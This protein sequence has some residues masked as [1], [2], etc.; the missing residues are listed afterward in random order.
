M[1]LPVGLLQ[2]G[3]RGCRV[4]DTRVSKGIDSAETKIR[5]GLKIVRYGLRTSQGPDRIDYSLVEE[6]TGHY[7][8]P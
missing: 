3:L 4:H 8:A 2:I 6:T 1:A 7:L 5:A